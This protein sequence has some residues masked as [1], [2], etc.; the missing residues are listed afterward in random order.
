MCVQLNAMR[1]IAGFGVVICTQIYIHIHYHICTH[2]Y[3]S[4]QVQTNVHKHACAY[5]R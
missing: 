5:I 1:F 3:V 2:M 4:V